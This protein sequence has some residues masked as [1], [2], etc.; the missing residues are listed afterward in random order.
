MRLALLKQDCDILPPLDVGA[1]DFSFL[2][3]SSPRRFGPETCQVL[4]LLRPTPAPCSG[5]FLAYAGGG[6]MCVDAALPR[7]DWCNRVPVGH[8]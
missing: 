7:N 4:T 5:E 8:T 6:F 2:L 1:S 3:R